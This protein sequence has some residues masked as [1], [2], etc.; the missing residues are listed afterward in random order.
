L[1]CGIGVVVGAQA[2][3][4]PQ[5]TRRGRPN[6]RVEALHAGAEGSSASPAAAADRG[7][8]ATAAWAEAAEL[9]SAGLYDAA[10]RVLDRAGGSA[11]EGQPRASELRVVA[12]A[13]SRRFVEARRELEQN[14]PGSADLRAAVERLQ[15]QSQGNFEFLEVYGDGLAGR[16]RG[17]VTN[18]ARGAAATAAPAVELLPDVADFAG[19]VEVWRTEAGR[20]LKTTRAVRAGELLMVE[21][22]LVRSVGPAEGGMDYPFRLAFQRACSSSPR[23]A[24]A[25]RLL[26]GGAAVLPMVD[27]PDM[28][29]KADA[30]GD[31]GDVVE[32]DDE[33]ADGIGWRN[34][35]N[36]F[37]CSVL[38]PAIAMTNHSCCPNATTIAVGDTNFIRANKAIPEGEEVCISYFDVLKPYEQRQEMTSKGF[39]FECGCPR[40][41][42]EKT[43]PE[44]LRREGGIVDD[45]E[46][47]INDPSSGIDPAGRGAAWIRGGHAKVYKE[48]LEAIFPFSPEASVQ[49][50]R[51]LRA[52]EATDPGSFTHC[53]FA[54]LDW[55]GER[56]APGAGPQGEATRRSMQYTD[57][58]HQT[59]YG[60]VPPKNVVD[61]LKCTQAA[62]E[63]VGVGEEFCNP[64]GAAF[65][66]QR[67][68]SAASGP[69]S[70]AAAVAPFPAAP[71]PAAPRKAMANMELLD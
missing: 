19:P 28:G 69:G 60:P 20:M 24:R 52:I 23:A 64:P 42:F 67:P 5:L 61:L 70:A 13:G 47:A 15:R 7:G 56:A 38:Y 48:K 58:V 57:L 55:L 41:T 36:S 40:C 43:L 8:G 1:A 26:A 51:L 66:A 50:A 10:V 44:V 68:S 9:C 59:R 35:F 3:C 33:Q 32:L 12:L 29:W 37:G 2:R 31:L 46:A 30:G 18:L 25:S 6:L 39:H 17:G 62:L 34:C 14:L 22:P 65:G 4:R 11:S 63:S 21:W 27:L 49:R 16:R 54:L 45:I 53:K 71:P